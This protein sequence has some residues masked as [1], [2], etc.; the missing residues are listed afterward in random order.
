MK[1]TSTKQIRA[2]Y[3]EATIRVYQA[4]RPE[5]GLSALQAQRF[6]PPFK[7]GRMTWIKPSFNW[8]MYRC[9]YGTKLGQEV[10]LAIDIHREGFEWAL[11]N[12]VPSHFLSAG[13]SE[14][15]W[16]AQLELKPVR[17]QWDP[18]RDALGREMKKI[19]SIQI[20]LSGEASRRYVEDWTVRIEDVTDIAKKAQLA[21]QNGIEDHSLPCFFER[22]YLVD[23]FA[24]ALQPSPTKN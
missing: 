7:L 8:M 11:Q 6:V 2:I 15:E 9:G 5:I 3:D 1:T 19:R 24:S 13:L 4:Y 17:V 18:E 23:P 10:V 20:G 14:S 12:S 21:A 22:E 16:R